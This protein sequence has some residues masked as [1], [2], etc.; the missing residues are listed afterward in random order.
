MAERERWSST[1]CDD[2][3]EIIV[4]CL[5]NFRG[6]SR[7]VSSAQ[8]EMRSGS[9]QWQFSAANR[10]QLD[11]SLAS[12]DVGNLLDRLG[13]G[14]AVRGGNAT[15]VGKIGWNGAP[16]A[17]DYATL[18]GEM[19]LEAS[20]GQFLKLDPGAGKLLGLLSLQGLARRFSLDFGDVF[21][22]GLAFDSISSTLTNEPIR[23]IQKVLMRYW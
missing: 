15:M 12:S 14:G 16:S 5:I 8:C 21:R 1:V 11:F 18:S 13:H 17:L 9:G 2:N 23:P 20:K 19:T 4:V 3:F 10:T 6:K 22:E 7:R